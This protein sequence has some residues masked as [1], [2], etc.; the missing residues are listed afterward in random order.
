VCQLCDA[1]EN[2]QNGH[3]VGTVEIDGD[4]LERWALKMLVGFAASRNLCPVDG[5]RIGKAIPP[6]SWLQLIFCET[7]FPEGCGFYFS[8]Q[9]I[10]E[11]DHSFAV[12]FF[13]APSGSLIGV[14]VQLFGFTFIVGIWRASD[15][16]T[17]WYRPRGFSLS[18]N[19]GEKGEILLS[20]EDALSSSR[21]IPLKL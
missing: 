8:E 18:D 21:M 4:A 5:S 19:K 17:L 13:T 10:R 12:H 16:R 7:D 2:W 9:P 1:L 20:W 14:G 11:V 3:S 15:T 6:E